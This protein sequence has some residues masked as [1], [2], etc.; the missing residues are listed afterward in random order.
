MR[1]IIM[2]TKG[3]QL[4]RMMFVR[5]LVF[6]FNRVQISLFQKTQVHKHFPCI[7]TY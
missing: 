1:E 6:T 4:C 3:K 7:K 2:L 5:I